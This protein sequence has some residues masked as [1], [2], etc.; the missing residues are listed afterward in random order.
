LYQQ[1]GNIG[2]GVAV[3]L[4]EWYDDVAVRQ[5]PH[6]TH[7][8]VNRSSSESSLVVQFYDFVK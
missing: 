6:S 8:F 7:L 3:Q 4:G 1:I 2:F 5:V